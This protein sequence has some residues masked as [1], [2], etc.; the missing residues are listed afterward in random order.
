MREHILPHMLIDE[1]HHESPAPESPALESPSQRRRSVGEQFGGMLSALLSPFSSPAS[2]TKR[3]SS[4][5]ETES[6][7]SETETKN[8]E[9]ET[10]SDHSSANSDFSSQSGGHASASDTA[11]GIT[12][13]IG[14]EIRCRDANEG[15]DGEWFAGEFRHEGGEVQYVL[16]RANA[17]GLYPR[18]A[19][20]D[21]AGIDKFLRCAIEDAVEYKV[22]KHGQRAPLIEVAARHFEDQIANFELGFKF[23]DA[24]IAKSENDHASYVGRAGGKRRRCSA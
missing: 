19:R 11:G 6:S 24:K 8:S 14:E 16:G 7:D 21:A 9:S 22:K 5:M 23:C 2:V 15:G 13:D 3:P 12:F 18:L 1:V 10:E 4:D 20:A 17:S